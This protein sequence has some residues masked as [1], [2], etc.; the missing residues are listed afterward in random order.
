MERI[1]ASN[2]FGLALHRPPSELRLDVLA[3][4][5][6][7]LLQQLV[8]GL[9]LEGVERAQHRHP[10]GDQGRE[11]TGEHRQLADA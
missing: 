9:V 4:A 7:R 10:R 11:L 1:E 6:D 2:T 5:A 3:Q 8:L